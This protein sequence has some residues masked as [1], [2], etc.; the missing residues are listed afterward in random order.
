VH[1]LSDGIGVV[2]PEVRLFSREGLV[3]LGELAGDD[4]RGGHGDLVCR[5]WLTWMCLYIA[6][7]F[8]SE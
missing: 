1:E 6:I 2:H 8:V 4:L 5:C 7:N 3:V